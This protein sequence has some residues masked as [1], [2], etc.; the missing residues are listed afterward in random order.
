VLDQPGVYRCEAWLNV[1]GTDMVWV[2]TNPIYV[3]PIQ[4]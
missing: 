3:D 1:A 2:L 4:P